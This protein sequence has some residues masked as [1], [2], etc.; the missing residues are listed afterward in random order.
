MDVIVN[1][2]KNDQDCATNYASPRRSNEKKIQSE[3]QEGSKG[4]IIKN[5]G[6]NRK[7]TLIVRLT[8]KLER[9]PNKARTKI[10]TVIFLSRKKKMKKLTQILNKK[11]GLS[12]LNE[13]LKKPKN[14]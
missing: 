7:L 6:K 12:L 14:I 11:N 8:M 13:E 2:R 9:D 4:N 3:E 1:T 10:K 5:F